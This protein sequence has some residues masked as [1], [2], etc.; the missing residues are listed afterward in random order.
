MLK[1]IVTPCFSNIDGFQHVNHLT[2]PMWFE[3]GREHLYRI[4]TPNYDLEHLRLILANIHV[5]YV[6]QMYLGSDVEIRTYTQ[7]VNNSSFQAYQEAWQNDVLCAKGTVV[8][9]H[10][11]FKANKSMRIPDDLRAKLEEHLFRAP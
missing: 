7:N 5:D 9:V 8:L 4:F 2:V 10:F 3:L 6:S 1:N 11:D